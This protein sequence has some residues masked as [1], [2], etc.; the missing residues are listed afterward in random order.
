MSGSQPGDSF[1]GRAEEKLSSEGG[2][3]NRYRR[4]SQEELLHELQ[5]HQIELEMQNEELQRS[6]SRLDEERS[7][8]TTL[9]NLAP[10][11]YF[12][13]DEEGRIAEVNYT[14]E[15]ML[16]YPGSRFYG[17][18]FTDYIYPEDQ[19]RFYFHLRE[20]RRKGAGSP[21][22]LRLIELDG[23]LLPV[24]I[25]SSLVSEE[26]TRRILLVLFDMRELH[27]THRKLE[28]AKREAVEASRAKSRF[29]ANMS[30]EIRTPMNGIMGMLELALMAGL[31]EPQLQHLQLA[32]E[33]AD[34]LLGIL[35][36][37]LDL[38]KIEARKLEL[39]PREFE[40]EPLIYHTV[41]LFSVSAS[42]KGLELIA[43]I[44]PQLPSRL[45]GDP[46]RLKQVLYNLLSNA[47]KFTQAGELLLQVRLRAC[48]EGA[49]RIAFS[50]RDT[51][52]GIAREEFDRLFQA[53]S[54]I[55]EGTTRSFGG[56]GLGLAI[57]AQ[58]VEM[59]GG[60]LQ[61]E[62]E[63]N[64]G[65]R[66]FFELSLALPEGGA[67]SAPAE[68]HAGELAALRVV[69]VEPHPELRRVIA[70]Y[71]RSIGVEELL[72]GHASAPDTRLFRS[73]EGRHAGPEGDVGEGRTVYIIGVG[74]SIGELLPARPE[75]ADAAGAEADAGPG[76]GA[77]AGAGAGESAI[78]GEEGSSPAFIRLISPEEHAGRAA[79]EEGENVWLLEK[80]VRFQSLRNVLREAALGTRA[81]S[82]EDGS[83]GREHREGSSREGAAGPRVPA[84]GERAG[85]SAESNRAPSLLVAEDNAINM[86]VLGEYFRGQGWKVLE[87][88][89]GLQALE[90]YRR[91][92]HS[93]DIILMDVQMPQMDGLTAARKI[94]EE[95]GPEPPPILALTAYAMPADRERCLQ[96]GMVDYVTKPI[97]SMDTL[98]QKMYRYLPALVVRASHTRQTARHDISG[99]RVLIA[100]D[101]RISRL[102]LS[103]MLRREGCCVRE[104]SEGGS[105]MEIVER[106]EID[107]LL[108]DY[109]LPD[110]SGAE[111]AAELHKHHRH[112]T[113]PILMVTGHDAA[114]VEAEA[115]PENI[116]KV[117]TKPVDRAELVKMI[118]A[119]TVAASSAEEAQEE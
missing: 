15:G 83:R 72:Y 59:M 68:P 20:V 104:V 94:R 23:G 30:H 74:R 13:L 40:I 45:F 22:D 75:P 113:I 67:P 99:Q 96:A 26:G 73:R 5:V 89:D 76:A 81:D 49:C 9:F 51:G 119:V 66:F 25:H 82:A 109:K 54:Q 41:G 55:E 77:G 80:P 62:S 105:V 10:V 71:L 117:L 46:V 8:F 24:R 65:S 98:M 103:R 114:E 12:S 18:R 60:S 53:F 107:V 34:H 84:P 91:E 88:G 16:G 111:I 56:T 6:Q 1:R 19:D 52:I 85:G 32:K 86:E 48:E 38:S 43:D 14:A 3:L 93:V 116:R 29:L 4:Y 90:L 78:A 70:R 28:E 27:E 33:S 11:G 7:K 36:D 44:D 79:A 101:E 35:N 57:S 50:C 87:A 69:L 61:V 108:L 47:L 42:R 100:E 95:A 21:Q 64:A 31:P 17:S 97:V 102:Y 92:R 115:L 106:E 118:A 37:I 2:R 39:E 58:L 112:G 110:R 63:R